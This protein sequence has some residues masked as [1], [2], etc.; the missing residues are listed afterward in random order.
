MTREPLDDGIVRVELLAALG[1]DLRAG[2]CT[3]VDVERLLAL[4]PAGS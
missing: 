1:P 2:H 4:V 3:P